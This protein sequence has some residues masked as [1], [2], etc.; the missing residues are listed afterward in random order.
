[1]PFGLCKAPAAFQRWIKEVLME[2]IDMCCI[3]YLDDVLIYSD[4]LLGHQRDVKNILEAIHIS[5]MKIKS[6]KCE[7]HKKATEYLAF[8]IDEEGIKV[9]PVKTQTIRDWTTP[10]TKNKIQ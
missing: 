1:M 9:D 10:K 8:I 7:F 4:T 2:D 6:S 3:V 5:G